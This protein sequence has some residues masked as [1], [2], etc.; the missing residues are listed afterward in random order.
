[1]K[2][3]TRSV[4]MPTLVAERTS[5]G[6]V[7]RRYTYVGVTPL[8]YEDITGGNAGYYQTGTCQGV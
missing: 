4:A 7:Q 5:T 2:Y 6:T 8:K 1:M 3:G